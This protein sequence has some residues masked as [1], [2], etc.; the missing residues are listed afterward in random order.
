MSQLVYDGRAA[1]AEATGTSLPVV[2]D[3]IRLGHLRTF[4]IGR[5]RKATVEAVRDWIDYLQRESDAGRPVC[6]RARAADRRTRRD[7]SAA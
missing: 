7:Q 4:L 6:Y 5:H 2:D 3:A 1:I